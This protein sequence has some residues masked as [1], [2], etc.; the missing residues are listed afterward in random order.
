MAMSDLQIEE[1]AL[2]AACGHFLCNTDIAVVDQ[3][4]TL[5][6]S[7][8]KIPEGVSPWEEFEKTCA[9]DLVERIENLRDSYVR[10]M[11]RARDFQPNNENGDLADHDQ[12][13]CA[14]CKNIFDN[15][16]SIQIQGE[17]Y[18]TSCATTVFGHS[19]ATTQKV[20]CPVCGIPVTMPADWQGSEEEAICNQCYDKDVI[21][22]VRVEYDLDFFGGDYDKVGKFAY[23][24]ISTTSSCTIEEAFEKQTG[25]NRQHIIHYST[26]ELYD[27][28]GA[29]LEFAQR[30]HALRRMAR[31]GEGRDNNLA[32]PC[33][34]CK[35]DLCAPEAVE[36]H[37]VNKAAGEDSGEETD[38]IGYGHY[39]HEGTF[40]PDSPADLSGGRYDLMDDS[41]RCAVCGGQL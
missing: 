1:Y 36:R 18:C 5:R 15:D 14:K 24:P 4:E 33:P 22:C 28:A 38:A 35:A 17:L 7:E 39:D 29:D 6:E 13:E 12:F 21:P 16:D 20:P 32:K 26:D 31:V 9:P 30:Q 8:Y 41:D 3:P 37:Y 10:A 23:I 27:P 2:E 25:I 40:E 11:K 34:H 19:A